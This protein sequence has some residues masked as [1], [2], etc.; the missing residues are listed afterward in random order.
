MNTHARR[1]FAFTLLSGLS[2]AFLAAAPAPAE[3]LKIIALQY[4][5]F[6]ADGR[7]RGDVIGVGDPARVF[8]GEAVRL[9]LVGS[10]IIGNV[11]R[12][13]PIDAR[14]EVA[15]G[16]GAI[17]I[18]R[19]G[20]SWVDVAVRGGSGNGLAQVGFTVTGNYEMRGKNTFGRLTLEIHE[21]GRPSSGSENN[22]D[23]SSYRTVRELTET[24]YRSILHS[25]ATGREAHIDFERIRSGGQQGA[26]DVAVALAREADQQGFGR[27]QRGRGYQDDD[28]RRA[29]ELYRALLKREQSVE[30]IWRLDRGFQNNV[31]VLHERG[32]A[33]LIESIVGSE[34]FARAWGF[35]R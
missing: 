26:L 22:S 7:Q 28:V 8:V 16:K 21:S 33:P 14:F 35:E 1:L 4:R 11:G 2:L 19:T 9:E 23:Q 13:V 17:D 12:E 10:A 15:A 25:P 29:G 3:P 34:E 32:L 5:L 6:D 30:E 18:V 20:R 24:L 27:S 31:R